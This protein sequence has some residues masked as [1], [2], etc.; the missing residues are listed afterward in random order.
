MD[1]S[2]EMLFGALVALTQQNEISWKICHDQF[3]DAI[4]DG[5]SVF[6][7]IYESEVKG[8]RVLF[9]RFTYEFADENDVLRKDFSFRL[10]VLDEEGLSETEIDDKWTLSILYEIVREKCHGVSGW[11]HEV[12]KS[13]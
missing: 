9:F 7:H 11:I 10:V 8:K 1:N 3:S 4:F 13:F 6:G 12:V 2:K 5:A